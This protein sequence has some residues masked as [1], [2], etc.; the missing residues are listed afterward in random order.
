LP[1][2]ASPV[3][4]NTEIVTQDVNG[5]LAGDAATWEQ[6]LATLRNDPALCRRMGARG[7]AAVEEKYCLQVTA[8]RLV[9]LLER[10][11]RNG[12]R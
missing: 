5:F 3:S 7:R 11:V 2:V 12:S 8:P 1:V 10:A 6:A 9:A 4:V